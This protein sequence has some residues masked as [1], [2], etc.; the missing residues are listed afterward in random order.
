MIFFKLLHSR[1]ELPK[2]PVSAI[3]IDL[4]TTNSSVAE[5]VYDPKSG[6]VRVRCLEVAQP[7]PDGEYTHVIVPS[8]VALSDGKEWVGEGAKRLQARSA[9][10]GLTLYKDLFY[11]CKNEIGTRREYPR[12]Q[13]GY[14]TPAEIGGKVLSFL[15]K[16]AVADLDIAPGRTAVTVPAS[17]QAG[18]RND[19]VKAC[20]IAGIDV[21]GG[22]LLDEPVAAFLDYL[23]NYGDRIIEELDRPKNLVVFDFGGGTCDVA[24][25]EVCKDPHSQGLKLAALSVSRYHRLGGGDIDAAIL[26]NVLIPQLC[27]QNSLSPFDLGYEDKRRYVEPALLGVAESLKIKL[28]L[29]MKRLRQFGKFD[30]ADKEDIREKLPGVYPCKIGNKGDQRVYSLKEPSLSAAEFEE[31]LEPFVDT[32]LVFVNDREYYTTCSIFAP[33][34]DAIS[35][36]GIQKEDVDY[37]LMVGGSSLIPQMIDAVADYLH[38]AQVLTFPDN[39]ATQTAVARGAAYHALA[40]ELTGKGLVQP[41]VHDDI[42]IRTDRGRHVLV[43]K[44]SALPHP[45]DKNYSVYAGLAVP[46]SSANKPVDLRVELV[47]GDEDRTLFHGIWRISPPVRKGDKLILEYKYDE[48]Q[49]LKLLLALAGESGQV[50]KADIE[51]PLTN[52]ANPQNVRTTILEAEDAIRSGKVHRDDLPSALADLADDYRKIG[53]RE[54]A[55]ELL[56][57][58]LRRINAPDAHILNLMGIVCGEMGDHARAEKFYLEA[59]QA[60]YEDAGRPLFNLALS[61]MNRGENAKAMATIDDALDRERTGPRLTLKAMLAERLKDARLREDSLEEA[62]V[63]FSPPGLCSDW[64]LSWL[65]TASRMAGDNE[66]HADASKEQESRRKSGRAPS[67]SGGLLPLDLSGDS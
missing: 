3:G 14:R 62:L 42:C 56:K 34:Q 63:L 35:R 22:G 32:D 5:A 47:A 40:L 7:T 60:D 17:F 11:Q 54:K 16:S 49:V 25:F 48:N 20:Q 33:L 19:T 15:H 36:S 8:V 39:D 58:A 41:I 67:A 38:L 28:C 29:E 6:E 18:Q 45:A 24:V 31:V 44:G 30:D 27:E 65:A 9:D 53:H 13:E 52:V 64:E 23:C 51:N 59:A 61:R 21:E 43:P 4:G 26:H 12:A 66:L 46:A 57:E 10:K 1:R 2:D 50:F 55:L 37:C